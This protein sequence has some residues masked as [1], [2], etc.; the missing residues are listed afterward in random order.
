MTEIKYVNVYSQRLISKF[1]WLPVTIREQTKWL[2][3]VEI[4]QIAYPPKDNEWSA[5]SFPEDEIV[6][7]NVSF[8][9][10]REYD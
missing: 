4:L 8:A 2:Q 9:P 5:L 10:D 3:R 7:E 6:W 1:L